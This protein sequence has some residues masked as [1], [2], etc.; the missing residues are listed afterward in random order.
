M[1]SKTAWTDCEPAFLV[2]PHRRRRGG[3]PH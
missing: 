1:E 2:P 3:A